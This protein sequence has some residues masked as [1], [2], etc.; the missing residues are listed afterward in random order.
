MTHHL[1]M[2]A[3]TADP[4]RLPRPLDSLPAVV[5]EPPR[6]GGRAR[7]LRALLRIVTAAEVTIER[8]YKFWRWLAMHYPPALDRLGRIVA[9]LTCA[10][11]AH[12]VPAYRDFVARQRSSRNRLRLD[13][14]PPTDKASYAAAYDFAA[15]CRDGRICSAG[16]NV[17]ES[18]GSSGAP[19]NWV[20]SLAELTQTH[21]N[22]ANFA[23][24]IFPSERLFV[25]NAFSM[26]AWATGINVSRALE[27]VG[28]VKSIGPDCAAILETMRRF[29]PG[30]DYLITAYPPFLKKVC[31]VMD[32]TGFDW[33]RFR[34]NALV[35][36]EPLTEALRSYLERRFDK[37]RSGYGASDVQIGIA[38]E[39][40][41]AVW[42]RR[43]LLI[44]SQ[45]RYALIGDGEDR[46]PMVFQYNP[47]DN[48]IEVNDEGELLITA[49]SANILS[50]KL[51]YNLGDEGAVLPFAKV[52]SAVRAHVADADMHLANCRDDLIRLPVLFLFGRRDS[53]IS[54]MGANIYPQDVE[55]GLYSDAGWASDIAGFCLALEEDCALDTFPAVHVELRPSTVLDDDRRARMAVALRR[56]IVSHI[57]A[58][59]RDFA[60]S[61]AED[62]AIADI[63]IHLTSHGQ[64]LFADRAPSI[65]NRYFV[66]S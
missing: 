43:R 28:I 25:L 65:K 58:I 35:G 15:R 49:T 55:Y 33:Q 38:G 31:D 21:A 34:L 45:L 48:Y 30:H 37:V 32:E 7:S 12:E 51:R 46:I 3:P 1:S 29:G 40:T 57:A 19:F 11:A 5:P 18:S 62:P 52:V 20:R 56:A 44:D 42:L 9:A 41:F 61:V 60:Q 66:R 13:A 64:G 8:H 39:T 26:G 6:R 23:R 50:P 16:V 59:N 17:D 27:R 54:Y 2:L 63:R 47:L 14:W 24:L 22:M 36:G 4:V 53:T 10:L